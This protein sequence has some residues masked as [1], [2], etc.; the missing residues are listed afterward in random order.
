M[1]ALGIQQL[2]RPRAA[3]PSGNMATARAQLDALAPT[4]R[5][6]PEYHSLNAKWFETEDRYSEAEREYQLALQEAPADV[7]VRHSLGL[8][9]WK[10][11]ELGEAA[12]E[13]RK[14]AKADSHDASVYFDLG[15]PLLAR[16]SYDA[17]VA[18]FQKAVRLPPHQAAE[19][20]ALASALLLMG[21]NAQAKVES[22]AADR[23]Q[24]GQGR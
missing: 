9:L 12:D 17:A 19:H 16:G 3:M 15:W 18:K 14:A 8:L 10:E 1:L 6:N 13:L 11:G 5:R 21:Q 20:R 22:E 4:H 24:K 7:K 2:A 23:L